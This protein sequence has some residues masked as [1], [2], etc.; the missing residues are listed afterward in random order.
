MKSKMILIGAMTLSMLPSS[1]FAQHH[2]SLRHCIDHALEHSISVKQQA[3]TVQKQEV[4]LSTARNSRLPNLEA[5]ISENMS[6]GRGKDEMGTYINRNTTAT[7]FSL[8]TSVPLLTGFQIPNTIKMRRLNLEAATATLEKAKNDIRVQVAQAYTQVLYDMEISGVAHRQVAIDS[9]QVRRVEGLF[10]NGKASG[11]E[12]SQQ[13]S[14][15]AQ[16]RLTATQADNRLQLAVLALTQ[17]LELPSP[18]GFEV[19]LPS[20]GVEAE[21]TADIPSPDLI[22]AEALNFRPEVRADQQSLLA[23]DYSIKIARAG[24]YPKLTFRA[25]LGT[26]YNHVSGYELDSFGRQ[27]KNNFNQNLALSLSVPIFN[28]FQT[29][30]DI[31]SARHDKELQSLKL[32]NTKKSLY[33]EIQQAY[34]NTLGAQSKYTSCQVAVTSSADAFRLMQAK[35]ENG[36]ATMTEFNEA[37]NNYLKAE[38]ECVQARY[39]CLYQHA[40]IRFYRGQ[41]LNY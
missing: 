13:R 26:S 32:E 24:Y 30:N 33:K 20:E 23:A 4:Q 27:L 22:Y 25:G 40:L 21:M 39:E 28:R 18:D 34:Y 14:S 29:R 15:L 17:L 38:S 37:K 6:F 3:V 2:W 12:L 10:N 19:Q 9:L 41:E 36:K 11:A 31:R 7:D 8:S 16:S 1:L 5:S 35:Y